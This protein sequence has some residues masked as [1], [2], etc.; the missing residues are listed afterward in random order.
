MENFSAFSYLIDGLVIIARITVGVVLLIAGIAKL[1]G[2]ISQFRKMILGYE[3]VSSAVATA[4]ARAFPV[5]EIASGI[6][7]IFGVFVQPASWVAI[8]L[9]ILFTCAITYSLIRGKKNDCGCFGI[10]ARKTVQWTLV[11]RN[12][13]FLCVLC[14]QLIRGGVY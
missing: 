4:L 2:G 6:C 8:L 12:I 9:L 3:I 5:L 14:V 13:L 11:Y 10:G 1:R 7:L